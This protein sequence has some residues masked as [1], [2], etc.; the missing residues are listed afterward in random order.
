MI[1]F[2]RRTLPRSSCPDTGL[3]LR[4][5]CG[6]C[7][8]GFGASLLSS[9]NCSK[10]GKSPGFRNSCRRL[11]DSHA[12]VRHLLDF[13]Y[14]ACYYRGFYTSI[15]DN[16][17]ESGVASDDDDFRHDAN[18]FDRTSP[19]C[20]FNSYSNSVHHCLRR[21]PQNSFRLLYPADCRSCLRRRHCS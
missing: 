14:R 19:S 4:N 15:I 20:C 13:L 17:L 5:R 21:S 3:R 10:N 6:S 8:F 7:A 1:H 18:C 16:F 2:H 12:A 11:H 9:S